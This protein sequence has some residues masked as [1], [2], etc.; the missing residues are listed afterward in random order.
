MKKILFMSLL[1]ATSIVGRAQDKPLAETIA[2]TYLMN[3]TE[4]ANWGRNWFIEFKGGASAF[5]GSPIGCGDVF[6]RLTPAIQIGVG[7]WFTPAA[8]GRFS[9]QGVQFVDAGFQRQRYHALHADFLFNLTA[10]CQQ[11]ELCLSRWDI[12][13]FFGLGMIQHDDQVSSTIP[14]A[15]Y[16]GA[17]ARYR[18]NNRL[19]LVAEVSNTS[20]ARTFDAIGHGAHLGDNLL[21]VSAGLSVS[22]GKVGYHR[23]VDAAPYMTQCEEL[24]DYVH[25]LRDRNERLLDIHQKD[26]RIKAE[27]RKILEIEGLLELYKDSLYDAQSSTSKPLYPRN[28]YSGLNSLRA[29]LASKFN[30]APKHRPTTSSGNSAIVNDSLF[31]S[32][33]EVPIYFFFQINT[34]RLKEETQLLNVTE[35]ARIAKEHSLHIYISGAADSATGT[36]HINADLS[37]RRAEYIHQLMLDHGVP[38]DHIETTFSGGIN[39]YTPV[40]ANRHTCVRLSIQ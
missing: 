3:V 39:D 37:H 38:E 11:N 18:L 2:P 14:F 9:Y 33:I 20:A 28:N 6:D 36:P 17:E 30:T 34:A 4:A 21:S 13:P 15:L 19:Q 8:G 23:I 24:L 22:L 31:Q 35:L 1:C 5:L 29:R 40:E 26:E 32:A 10:Y 27:Y 7:K 16:Y 25:H 12:I